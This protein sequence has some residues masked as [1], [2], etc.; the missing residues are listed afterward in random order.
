MADSKM[1]SKTILAFVHKC[2]DGYPCAGLLAANINNMKVD[3]NPC[4]PDRLPEILIE[5]LENEKF[6][7]QKPYIFVMDTH[8]PESRRNEPK[9]Q[10]LIKDLKTR[11]NVFI[12][13]HHETGTWLMKEKGLNACIMK[14]Y[15]SASRLVVDTLKSNKMT[16]AEREK[17]GF[18]N[19]IK[20]P[21]DIVENI[22]SIEKL[23]SYEKTLIEIDKIDTGKTLNNPNTRY[24]KKM[25]IILRNNVGNIIVDN[26]K[27]NGNIELSK[28]QV[29]LI[30]SQLKSRGYVIKDDARLHKEL[31]E[32]E[33]L[34]LGI[35]KSGMVYIR[36]IDR[37]LSPGYARSTIKHELN[38]DI[39]D[40]AV[41]EN[42]KNRKGYNEY[43]AFYR[44][45]KDNVDV[46]KIAG[47]HSGGGRKDAASC[48]IKMNAKDFSKNSDGEYEFKTGYTLYQIK[49]Q[50]RTIENVIKSS[51]DSKS[52]KK[53]S[54]IEH[55]K[56]IELIRKSLDIFDTGKGI[57]MQSIREK[58]KGKN[59][60]T[61]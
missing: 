55:E 53:T 16:N 49:E 19:Y 52:D 7:K 10:E 12:I 3:I 35:D 6:S 45:M 22:N 38:S 36:V 21:D 30:E 32:V 14:D 60:I 15:P 4:T 54:S 48:Y 46:S 51:K 27:N 20:L 29:E 24:L 50:L 11:G 39:I 25:F 47:V 43:R 44:P 57:P 40:Y 8:I 2:T 56:K 9:I 28:K 1:K 31:I 58:E 17:H 13:D 33:K 23:S 41:I 59:S 42:P 26:I 18:S 61:I 34:K 37:N 5:Q